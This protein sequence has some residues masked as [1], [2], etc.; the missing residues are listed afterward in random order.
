MQKEKN[1]I[2]KDRRTGDLDNVGA[3]VMP[4][5]R[6]ILGRK[7]FAEADVLCNW[8]EIVGEEMASF[9]TPL[10]IDFKKNERVKGVLHVEVSGGAFAL[11]LQ[12]RSRFLIDK[13]NTFF[14]YEAIQQIKILQ[15]PVV[16]S[17]QVLYNPEKRLVTAEEETY[18]EKL[19]EGVE[20]P[21]LSRVLQNLGRAVLSNKRSDEQ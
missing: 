17:P 11:E 3:V 8:K 15:N 21:E 14:G 13:V 6:K 12:L 10:K 2:G 4:L 5:A 20:H 16:A 7:A 18:I 1:F 9:S 19:S